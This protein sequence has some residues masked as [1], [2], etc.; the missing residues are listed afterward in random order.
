MVVAAAGL[1][2]VG[3]LAFVLFKPST[4][5]QTEEQAATNDDVK[6]MKTDVQ[7]ASSLYDWHKPVM[8][9]PEIAPPVTPAPTTPA[10]PAVPKAEPKPTVKPGVIDYKI[11]AGDM[12]SK[13]AV[14]YGCTT[15]DIYKVNDGLDSGNAHKLR[16]GQTIRIP[17]GGDT[18]LS[19]GSETAGA[20]QSQG[21]YYPRRVITAAAGDSAMQL[22]VEHYGSMSLF[23]MIMNANPDLSWDLKLRGGEQVVLP[24][25]GNAPASTATKA[26]TDSVERNSLIP[27]RR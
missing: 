4:D 21:D 22:A 8:V 1:V 2:L 15:S 16:V 25:F 24:E 12:V 20:T 26:P 6:P 19:A 17:V 9:T 23:R 5:E 11:Q 7:P 10:Q 14:K 3:M 13:L 18:T 27:T